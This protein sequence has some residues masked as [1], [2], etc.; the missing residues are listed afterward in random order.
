MMK[1][2]G[3]LDIH[4]HILPGIDDGSRNWEMTLQM[5]TAA[6][7]Q[8][9]RQIVATPHNYP[10]DTQDNQKILDLAGIV[11]EIE[12]GHIL[13]MAKSRHLLVE[14]YPNEQYGKVYQ[15]LKELVEEGYDPILAHME[16]VHAVFEQESNVRELVK[17]GVLLQ[18]NTG[19]LMGGAFDRRSARL[20]K[21][22]EANLIHFLGANDEK[23]CGEAL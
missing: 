21:Y 20:R 7:G 9:V 19:S 6:Y 16:R 5:L 12:K 11:E 4:S 18:V 10:N 15:G 2:I 23:L 14:F 22:I 13:T 3:Y 17:M 8:G 1:Q